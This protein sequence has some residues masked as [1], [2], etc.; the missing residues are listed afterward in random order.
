MFAVI[1]HITGTKTGRVVD[2][3]DAT[4]TIHGSRE[5]L[6][7]SEGVHFVEQAGDDFWMIGG[8]V[9]LFADLF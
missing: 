9:V 2:V 6:A 5:S 3:Q 7:V 1:L 8:D 4:A